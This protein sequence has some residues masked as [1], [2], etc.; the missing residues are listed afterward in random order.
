MRYPRGTPYQG[1]TANY[2]R[3]TSPEQNLARVVYG[4]P[5]PLLAPYQR[6][7]ATFF[8]RL[9]DELANAHAVLVKICGSYGSARTFASKLR[10]E[11][12]SDL[13]QVGV[14]QDED[15]PRPNVWLVIV[16]HRIT[17][18]LVRPSWMNPSTLDGDQWIDVKEAAYVLGLREQ[19]TRDLIHQ[20]GIPHR[21]V[22][23][24][25]KIEIRR[26]TL[27]RLANRPGR[28][29]RRKKTA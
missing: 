3:V 20:H 10:P 24:R 2:D 13:Y 25:R 22:G 15:D 14:K 11:L 19:Q 23:G 4:L 12:P 9:L 26:G 6:M 8:G 7:D 27:L 16:Y 1:P 18:S 21:V 29:K 5:R 28:W 17:M